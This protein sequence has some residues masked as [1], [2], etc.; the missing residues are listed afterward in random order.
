M[1]LCDDDDG[2]SVLLLIHHLLY[3]SSPTAAAA[4]W[5]GNE[6]YGYTSQ[7][8]G[9]NDANVKA[10]VVVVIIVVIPQQV[11]QGRSGDALR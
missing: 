11:R 4:N 3:S 2:I 1:N 10:S 7:W 9:I 6:E 8:K 5:R